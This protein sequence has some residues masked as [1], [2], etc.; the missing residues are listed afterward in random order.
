MLIIMVLC[1]DLFYCPLLQA[2]QRGEMSIADVMGPL[3]L[4]TGIETVNSRVPLRDRG[5][6]GCCSLRARVKQT[7]RLGQMGRF[8]VLAHDT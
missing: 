1:S 3:T 5:T 7:E 6:D 4:D 2:I 8:L